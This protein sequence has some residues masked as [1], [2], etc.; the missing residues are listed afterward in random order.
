MELTGFALTLELCTC[1]RNKQTEKTKTEKT[2]KELKGK[3]KQGIREAIQTTK[4]STK[5]GLINNRVSKY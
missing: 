4:S 3:G 2:E 5:T 1:K